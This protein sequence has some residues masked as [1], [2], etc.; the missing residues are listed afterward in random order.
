LEHLKATCY[1]RFYYSIVS[2]NNF[3]ET[4]EYKGICKKAS[5][6]I[7][8]TYS[9]SQFSKL[10]NKYGTGLVNYYVPKGTQETLEQVKGFYCLNGR[11]SYKIN[12][13]LYFINNY[14]SAYFA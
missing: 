3:L 7:R 2:K 10:V 5:S 13:K 8:Q 6:E 11:G 14:I 9:F 4:M 12:D 1:V